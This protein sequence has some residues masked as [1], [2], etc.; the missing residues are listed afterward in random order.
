MEK[1]DLMK[2]VWKYCMDKWDQLKLRI[3]L[4]KYQTPFLP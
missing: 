2:V 4:A 1:K 3:C